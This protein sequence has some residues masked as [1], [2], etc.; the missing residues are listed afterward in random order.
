MKIRYI[1]IKENNHVYFKIRKLIL[2]VINLRQSFIFKVLSNQSYNFLVGLIKEKSII[3]RSIAVSIFGGTVTA[4]RCPILLHL[5]QSV[6][7]LHLFV[8]SCCSPSGFFTR[9][10]STVVP[11]WVTIQ[12]Y[13]WNSLHLLAFQ[14]WL[15]LDKKYRA[16][17]LS[18]R[19]H[20]LITSLAIF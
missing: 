1:L 3:L 16:L 12:T 14:I 2:E 5:H 8:F 9:R 15:S 20:L 17:S 18:S 6:A 19:I 7:G 10:L 11:R 13:F 4:R